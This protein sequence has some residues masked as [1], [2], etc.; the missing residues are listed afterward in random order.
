MGSAAEPLLKPLEAGHLSYY[1]IRLAGTP[2]ES[3]GNLSAL[4][5]APSTTT[6]YQLARHLIPPT[7][8]RNTHIHN[9][10]IAKLHPSLDGLEEMDWACNGIPMLNTPPS[11]FCHLGVSTLFSVRSPRGNHI[12][13]FQGF[14]SPS[15]HYHGA[16]SMEL[17]HN[18]YLK[19]SDK[20]HDAVAAVAAAAAA[21]CCRQ[22]FLS[23]WWLCL[24]S[25]F[26]FTL[27]QCLNRTCRLCFRWN[28]ICADLIGWFRPHL[29]VF[30]C[31][32]KS[33]IF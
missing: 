15:L 19:A 7:P 13:L 20:R 17:S 2:N 25:Y 30:L 27:W 4:W 18:I 33:V 8:T 9:P 26:Q 21:V 23:H 3:C 32:F 14:F 10:V 22:S 29:F 24:W 31:R 12:G 11:V 16:S 5:I 28:A 1:V 6:I